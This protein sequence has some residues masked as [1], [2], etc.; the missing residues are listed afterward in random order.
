MAVRAYRVTVTTTPTKLSDHDAD[1]RTGSAIV[2]RPAG[3]VYV[4]GSGVTTA[5][6][7]LVA[8]GTE[9]ALDLDVREDLYA[10]AASGTVSV[11]VLRTAA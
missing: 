9:L 5:A 4:G 11:S 2:V 6:G 7:Y 8:G 10:V 3:D 1:A